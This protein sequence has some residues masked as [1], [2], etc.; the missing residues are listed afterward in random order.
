MTVNT[1]AQKTTDGFAKLWSTTLLVAGT[2]IGAGMLGM[3]LVTAAAGFWPAFCVT[4]AAWLFMLITGLLL[5][6]VSYAMPKGSNL[7]T[8]SEQYLGRRG[9][10]LVGILF[11]FLYYCL[12]VAYFAAGSSLV[13][14]LLGIS[15]GGAL[16]VF[17]FVFGLIVAMGARSIDRVNSI[18]TVAMFISY[19]I[20]I[21]LGS[22]AVELAR[23]YTSAPAASILALPVL[24]SAFGYHNI[25]P[26]LTSYSSASKGLLRWAIF[27][28]T[29][30]ALIIFLLWQWMIIGS[31][32]R[33]ALQ[34]ALLSGQPV[35]QALQAV[36]KRPQI[37]LIGQYFAFFALTTSVLGVCFSMVDF[38]GEAL[39]ITAQGLKRVAL[40]LCVFTP[41]VLSVLWNPALFDK[42]LGLAGGIGEAFLNGL[43]PLTFFVLYLKRERQGSLSSV[44]RGAL[45][46][47]AFFCL[48]V[49]YIELKG[50]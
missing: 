30:L 26:S 46:L 22:G 3:P 17:A 7:L 18:L 37:Y 5:L 20:L 6:E 11:I 42:A 24:F 14:S 44:T 41:P 8:L 28:G 35:T 48:W 32:P 21:A 12:L 38:L 47:L 49:V 34:Q 2:T 1:T 39:K 50:L 43:V 40:T 15:S 19:G 25:I 4:I 9:K 27:L 33:E 36:A 13:S 16:T 45:A 10:F 29:T 31:I 23:L